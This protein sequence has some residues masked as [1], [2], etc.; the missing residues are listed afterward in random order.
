MIARND[1]QPPKPR[2]PRFLLGC[3]VAT[4]GALRSLEEAGQD[5]MELFERHQCG[6]WGE[7]CKEDA[8]LNKQAIDE[9][10]R[11]LSAYTLSSGVKVW[12]ITESDRSTSTILL[13]SEY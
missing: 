12:L 8:R 5:A 2:R 13:P 9:G 11:I 1:E 3:R 6:E 7:V 10:N 4:P